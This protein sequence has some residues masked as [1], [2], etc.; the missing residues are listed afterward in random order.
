MTTN[1]NPD[2][3]GGAS[4]SIAEVAALTRR[5]RELSTAGRDV[6]PAE[7]AAFLADKDAL[8]ARI[9]DAVDTAT[10]DRTRAGFAV[11]RPRVTP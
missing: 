9:T 2:R 5:L 4:P 10:R 3:A 7:R 1:P 8:I 11:R 6:D